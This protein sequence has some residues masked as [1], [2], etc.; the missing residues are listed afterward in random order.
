MKI[1]NFSLFAVLVALLSFATVTSCSRTEIFAG[2]WQGQ[3]ERMDVPDASN[4]TATMT[5]DFAPTD[6]R[7]GSGNVLLSAVIDVQQ[8]VTADNPFNIAYE[9]SVAATASVAGHYI[10]PEGEDDE[11]IITFDPSS[12]QVNVDRSGVTYSNNILTGIPSAQLDSLTAA[13]A[14]HWRVILTP[15]I[16]DIFNRYATIDDIE[17]HGNDVLKCEMDHKDY[18][19]HRV[20]V[21]D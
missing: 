7:A 2:E 3:P 1:F 4:A 16:R 8:P 10:T 20:G 15:A 14:D 17:V 18:V 9:T 19:M 11:V 12:L 5:I 6:G 21:P 13:T